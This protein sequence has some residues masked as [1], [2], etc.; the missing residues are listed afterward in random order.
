MPIKS[1]V[2]KPPRWIYWSGLAALLLFAG[3]IAA[4]G[5]Q[6][7][8]PTAQPPAPAAA[9]PTAAPIETATPGLRP[10]PLPAPTASLPPP[11]SVPTAI[12]VT[13]SAT[14]EPT[15][16]PVSI[17]PT[18][19]QTPQP[20]TTTESPTSTP[21]PTPPDTSSQPAP[22]PTDMDTAAIMWGDLF[23]QLSTP[24]QDCMSA[25]LGA[26]LLLQVRQSPISPDEP[27]WGPALFTCLTP[28]TALAIPGAMLFSLMVNEVLLGPAGGDEVPPDTKE[29]IQ[30]LL[31]DTDIGAVLAT[32]LQDPTAAQMPN[33]AVMEFASGIESCAP[34]LGGMTG[35]PGGAQPMP[36]A[37][38]IL[39]QHNVTGWA[40]NAPTLSDGVVYVGAD[41]AKVYA[42]DAETGQQLWSFETN[43][44][45]RSRATI[46][47]GIVYVGSNDNNLYAL[48]AET[49]D[50]LWQ[51]DTGES[52]RYP[53]LVV[54]GSVYVPT[55]SEGG[56]N[57]HALDAASGAQKWV[58]SQYYPF[59]TGFE[60]G[61]GAA[62]DSD[63]DMLLV[64][65]DSGE[66][67]AL[68]AQ[69][70][71]LAWHF[72]GDVGTDTP[73]V[74][75]G[76]VVF[77]TA[78]NSAYALD[79]MTGA[80]LWKYSTDRFPAQGFTPV[81]DGGVYY[82]APDDHLYALDT[83]TGDPIWTYQLDSM[84]STATVVAEGAVYVA[85]ENGGFYALDQ[86]TGGVRW[87]INATENVLE[88]PTVSDGVLYLE[89]SDGY[90]LAL[91]ALTGDELWGFSKGFFSGIRTYT[92]A[93]GVL[94]FSSL[95]GAIY[96]ID[97][98]AA[99]MR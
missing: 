49:G 65:G 75:V 97:A 36:S 95:N 83:S 25:K 54:D 94:Y 61:I 93:D 70:G 19:S 15:R 8:A 44:V 23:D 82:F 55:T 46:S 52:V 6:Q 60:S 59:D 41:D 67:Y 5:E 96:A 14:P 1:A 91:D 32:V 62:S 20:S 89:S 17:E 98:S 69:T 64:I 16:A 7:P 13:P 85:S 21:S 33:Q 38:S 84:A 29:C 87:S 11:T 66:L 37:D 79:L 81:V 74:V 71:E 18:T 26:V 42:L 58:A 80:E 72:R 35:P 76:D 78:T 9:P 50:L 27:E 12:P 24:E 30:A 28:D 88:S 48:I 63:G 99:A 86:Q 56:R 43:D 90:L 2:F 68:D 51:H 31:V 73:P 4:C 3:L 77:V 45:V 22:S 53:P 57:V 47:N 40:M 10:P 39:W 92:L 34:Q